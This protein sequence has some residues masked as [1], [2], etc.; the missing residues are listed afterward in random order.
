MPTPT[1]PT[2]SAK[3]IGSGF[4]PMKSRTCSLRLHAHEVG[5]GTVTTP[6]GIATTIVRPEPAESWLVAVKEATPLAGVEAS[7]FR[8][9]PR[10]PSK[11]V[12][13]WIDGARTVADVRLIGTSQELP[14]A[15]Q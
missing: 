10:G 7:Q 15:F 8:V 11:Q 6:F 9:E 4:R 12:V 3:K 5:P 13:R 14:V 1:T 2:T